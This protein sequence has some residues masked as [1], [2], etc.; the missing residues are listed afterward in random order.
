M[1]C[2]KVILKLIILTFNHLT[3]SKLKL[4]IDEYFKNYNK[5]L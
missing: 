1:L 3:D 5:I 4:K 2:L